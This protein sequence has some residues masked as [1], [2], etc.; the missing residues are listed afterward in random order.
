MPT[1]HVSDVIRD[2]AVLLYAIVKGKSVD[3][4]QVIQDSITHAIRDSST[5]RLPHPSLICGL[6]KQAKVTWSDDEIL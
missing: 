5:G 4:G 3:V 2:R 1:T 6:C